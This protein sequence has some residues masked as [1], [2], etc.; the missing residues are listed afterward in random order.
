M[1]WSWNKKNKKRK[2]GEAEE[3]VGETT[4]ISEKKEG[5]ERQK[6]WDCRRTIVWEQRVI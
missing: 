1:T 3:E 6:A 5:T 4:K 2:K